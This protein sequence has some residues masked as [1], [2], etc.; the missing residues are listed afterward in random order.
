MKEPPWLTIARK[1]LGVHE[2]PGPKS[3][4]RIIEYDKATTLKA[5]S[6]EVPWCA[7][8]VSWCLEQAGIRSTRNAAAASYEDWGE[9]LG[10][11]PELGCVVVMSHHATFYDG[12]VDEDTI[13]GL[14]GNQSD[15]VKRSRYPVSRV[16]SYRWPK[17][18]PKGEE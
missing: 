12:Y 15:M 6:D 7:A 8:F 4:K 2:I 17:G 14:G 9:D 18:W 3:E 16:I 13:I 1:E 11:S 5:T 10:D